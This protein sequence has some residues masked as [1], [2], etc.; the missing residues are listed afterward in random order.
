MARSDANKKEIIENADDN[1]VQIMAQADANTAAINDNVNSRYEEIKAS[2]KW[3]EEKLDEQGQQLQHHTQLLEELLRTAQKGINKQDDL[4]SEMRELN[5]REE[6]VHCRLLDFQDQSQGG[7][8][9]IENEKLKSSINDLKQKARN[10]EANYKEESLKRKD[11]ER[12]IRIIATAA[13][14]TANKG[15]MAVHLPSTPSLSPSTS[16]AVSARQEF[17]VESHLSNSAAGQLKQAEDKGKSKSVLP[18]RTSRTRRSKH[19]FAA[20]GTDSND[21]LKD[22]G[23]TKL[24]G[25][26]QSKR[27]LDWFRRLCF[28][29]IC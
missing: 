26:T 7:K 9:Y 27:C 22:G 11:A 25:S 24:R 6:E 2:S 20:N 3:A 29:G 1:K 10:A 15:K 12:E 17:A 14:N 5:K 21:V 13:S 19:S 16:A 8:V 18:P 23:N 28:F 4:G